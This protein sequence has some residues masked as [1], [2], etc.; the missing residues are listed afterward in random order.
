MSSKEFSLFGVDS[1]NNPPHTP[2]EQSH[3]PEKVEDTPD[4]LHFVDPTN[5]TVDLLSI[6]YDVPASILRKT[7]G[8][9]AD[10]LLAARKTILISGEYYK[11]GLSLSPRPIDGE[12]M[13]LKKNKIRRFMVSCKVTEL[14]Q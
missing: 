2:P 13:D 4:V 10:H 6:R 5:D 12:E 8:I 3:D 1:Y 9:F 11:G 14:V 7:N